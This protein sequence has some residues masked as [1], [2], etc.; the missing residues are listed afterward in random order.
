MLRAYLLVPEGA[1]ENIVPLDEALE[2][3]GDFDPSLLVAGALSWVV[4]RIGHL[5]SVLCSGAVHRGRW[6]GRNSYEYIVLI[7]DTQMPGNKVVGEAM[8]VR[9]WSVWRAAD[10]KVEQRTQR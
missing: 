1:R 10:S 2:L 5:I 3:L 9:Q 8:D 7:V 6:P 4:G